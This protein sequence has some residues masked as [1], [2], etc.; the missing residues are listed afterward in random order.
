[1]SLNLGRARSRIF[2]VPIGCLPPRM[3]LIVLQVSSVG[4]SSVPSQRDAGQNGEA[5]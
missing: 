2:F 5:R 3:A 1:M 4:D